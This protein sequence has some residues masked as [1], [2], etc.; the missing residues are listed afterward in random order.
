MLL[1]LFALLGASFLG[2]RLI[3]GWLAAGDIPSLPAT[4]QSYTIAI[5]AGHGGFD[6]GAVGGNGTVEAGLNLA[7]AELL[8]DNLIA[9]GMS[10]VMTRDDA[11][12]LADT[13]REDME[14]RGDILSGESIDLVVSIHMNKYRDKSINGPRVFYLTGSAQG[15]ALAQTILESIC[16]YTEKRMIGPNPSDSYYVLK[17][18]VCPSVI[19]ECG[20]LSNGEDEALLQDP[21]YQEKLAEGI[22]QGIYKYLSTEGLPIP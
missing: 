22:A 18:N 5:D 3:K 14:I 12:A 17:Q 13:K 2:N 7:V 19:V 9:L 1:L 4:A 15:E 6:G 11:A 10:V 8:R 20:F 21:V 16:E